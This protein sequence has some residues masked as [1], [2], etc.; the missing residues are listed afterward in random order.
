MCALSDV[1]CAADLSIGPL[2]DEFPL[3]LATGHRREAVGP[4]FYSEQKES[5]HTWGIPPL[6]VHVED[7][8]VEAEEFDVVYP[9]ISYDRYGGEYR[10]HI[11][12]VFSFAGGKT[13]E[14]EQ[15]RRFTLFPFYFQ[16]RSP[17]PEDNYTAFLPFYGHLK[18]RLFRDDIKFVLLPLYVQTRKKDV[19]TDNYVYPFFH[20][21]H[22]HAL[23]GWQFWPIV[24]AEHKGI[25]TKTNS[26]DEVEIVGGHEKKFVLWPFYL[27][28]KTGIGTDNPQDQ[29]AILPLYTS[30][31]SPKR[32]SVTYF[33]PF[34][35]TR[36]EDREKNYREFGAP[37]PIIDF[38]RGP[39][40]HTSR[41]WPFYSRASNTNLESNFY[42]W[43]VYKYNRL[44][45]EPLDRERTRIMFFL[46]SDIS[47]KNTDTG[48]ARIRRDFWPFYTYIRGHEGNERL[49]VL[50]ILEPLLPNNKSVERSYSPL[51]SI[52]RSEKNKATGAKSQS[53]LWNLY[54]RDATPESKK[55]SL[56]FGLVQY[57]SGRA[58]KR[59]KIFYVPFGAKK[60]V[61]NSK[62]GR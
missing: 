15:K 30:L 49:Q 5:Q 57:E 34:G 44:H 2:Y 17:N 24:G 23:N 48:T 7:P 60:G 8:D 16:Q 58:G 29:F 54:R 42:L 62:A 35:Y 25:T 12:Q 14:D 46:Y 56:L 3:T 43:P 10:F 6:F 41:V 52:W 27:K 11:L 21:R 51:W 47:E 39:G 50:S 53:L 4:L 33:W 18:N 19:V 32:D 26:A 13:Q 40:K 61:Q 1:C 22:G 28:S 20:L 38:A 37:W 31:H 45:S 59:W 36:I 9:F 55:S